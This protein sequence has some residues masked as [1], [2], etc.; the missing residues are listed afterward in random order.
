MT[1]RAPIYST[2]ELA[3]WLVEH[4]RNY[5][6]H[7]SD[8]SCRHGLISAARVLFASTARLAPVVVFEPRPYVSPDVLR[9]T[10]LGTGHC[11]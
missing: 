5:P 11:G 7:G 8:C 10:T 3:T 1:D 4:D 2:R 9:G 6:Q